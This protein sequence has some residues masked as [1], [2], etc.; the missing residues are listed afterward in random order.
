MK[1]QTSQRRAIIQALNDAPGPL[2]PQEVLKQ[3]SQLHEGLGLATVYRNLNGLEGLGEV[4]A[5][6]LPNET[7]RYELAGRGHHH[8][9]RCEQC[10]G[11]FELSAKCPVAVLEGVT[12]PGGFKVE[13]HELTLYGRCPECAAAH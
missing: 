11:V 6:H 10:D 13:H 5:V 2:T 12:L 8:H 4:I 7:T 9:F 1:R 3:A